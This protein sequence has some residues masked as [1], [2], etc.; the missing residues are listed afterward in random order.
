MLNIINGWANYIWEDEEAERLANERAK[1]CVSCEHAKES[2]FAEIIDFK[3]TEMKGL[4]CEL[5][6]CPLTRLLRSEDAKC[7]ISKW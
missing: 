5:C 6:S 1:V 4:C 7:K 3:E 2:T